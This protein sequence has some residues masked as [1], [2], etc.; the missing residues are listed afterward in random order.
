MDNPQP[1]LDLLELLDWSLIDP[2][3]VPEG[4]L[5]ASGLDGVLLCQL[6]PCAECGTEVLCLVEDTAPT[7][8]A[9]HLPLNP[10]ND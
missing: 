2:G 4:V 1:L 5:V 6:R 10:N 8:C 3:P 9:D 7:S